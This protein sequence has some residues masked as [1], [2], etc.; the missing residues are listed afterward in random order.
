[1]NTRGDAS[2]NGTKK[3]A[4]ERA[5]K[6]DSSEKK[7]VKNLLG[8]V[9]K[10]DAAG[11]GV[12]KNGLKNGKNGNGVRKDAT[13]KSKKETS[14]RVNKQSSPGKVSA[15]DD[16]AVVTGKDVTNE[17]SAKETK[18][19]MVDTGK[20]KFSSG[21]TEKDSLEGNTAATTSEVIA[22]KE[23]ASEGT[24][25]IDTLGVTKEDASE[26]GD[27][28]DTSERVDE[29]NPSQIP[30]VV[31]ASEKQPSIE[32]T[33]LV[34]TIS[35]PSKDSPKKRGSVDSIEIAFRE[36]SKSAAIA[37]KAAVSGATAA[38]VNAATVA[39]GTASKKIES[40]NE[41][42][43]TAADAVKA[44][45][46]GATAAIVSAA[47]AVTAAVAVNAEEAQVKAVMENGISSTP[48]GNSPVETANGIAAG[49]S[50]DCTPGLQYSENGTDTS[51][52]D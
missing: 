40:S 39:K 26:G 50:S 41:M 4:S 24:A 47:T 21:G 30:A 14:H 45:V 22:E 34:K 18:S 11:V 36:R 25:K 28:K 33:S 16:A 9:A 5:T 7:A 48:K 20:P 31:N 42:A 17:V 38:F 23:S 44:A 12:K 46:S 51:R 6:K 8:T 1:M 13:E 37:V 32:K 52:G 15:K 19:E 27:K 2:E 43:S 35:S 49:S 3:A 10:K 29:E